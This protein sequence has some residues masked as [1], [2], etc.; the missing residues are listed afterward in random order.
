VVTGFPAGH[1]AT[2]HP[3]PEGVQAAMDADAGTL[4]V[5]EAPYAG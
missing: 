1:G 4:R 5:I 3:V 2:L